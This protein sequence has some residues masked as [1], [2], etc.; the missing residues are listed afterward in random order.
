MAQDWLIYVFVS[1]KFDDS[2]IFVDEG[3][4]H[5]SQFSNFPYSGASKIDIEKF[6]NHCPQP[7]CLITLNS[8]TASIINKSRNR[9]DYSPR[10][11][12][13]DDLMSFIT[14]AV[15]FYENLRMPSA[16]DTYQTRKSLGIF[17]S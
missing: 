15:D 14:Y 7:H 2:L 16:N 4:F 3:I 1:E 13:K 5:S 11:S 9:G 10:L 12:T 17:R 6:L 8:D